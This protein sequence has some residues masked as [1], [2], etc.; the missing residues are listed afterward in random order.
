MTLAAKISAAPDPRIAVGEMWLCMLG[1]LVQLAK[2]YH[3]FLVREIT[4]YPYG[5]KGPLFA[6][7][8]LGD[9]IG[10]FK[11]VV[12]ALRFAALLS[13]KIEKEIAALRASAPLGPHAFLSPPR[14][15]RPRL[16]A[17][18]DAAANDDEAWDADDWEKVVKREAPGRF[19]AFADPGERCDD[20]RFEALL[21]G[22]LKK[23]M[24]AICADLG[25]TP[26]WSLWTDAG[27]PAPPGGGEEDWAAFF[28]PGPIKPPAQHIWDGRVDKAWRPSSAPPDRGG[29]P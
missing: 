15:A 22:S 14:R 28:E 29:S 11:R 6:L 24:A 19:A 1:G 3:R 23:A 8:L 9:P 25:L 26:D 17:G 7:P 27:F 18:C 12:R 4:P 21:K 5:L 10:A 13:L 20:D 16:T 2:R